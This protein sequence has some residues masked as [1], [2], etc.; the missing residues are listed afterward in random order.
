MIPGYL[1]EIFVGS[2]PCIS[3][4]EE[5]EYDINPILLTRSSFAISFVRVMNMLSDSPCTFH[6]VSFQDVKGEKKNLAK[7][8]R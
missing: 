7:M 4:E 6:L 3:Q 5:P 8:P 1:Y 2:L